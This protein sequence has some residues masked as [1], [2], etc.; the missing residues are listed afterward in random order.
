MMP[1]RPT[2]RAVPPPGPATAGGFHPS[3]PMKG[4]PSLL[5]TEQ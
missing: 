4:P 1:V 5:E 3:Q 2:E